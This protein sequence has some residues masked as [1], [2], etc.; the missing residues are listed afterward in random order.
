MGTI[1][2]LVLLAGVARAYQPGYYSGHTSQRSAITFAVASGHVSELLSQIT[3]SCNPGRWYV[4]LYPHPARVS[5]RGNWSHRTPGSFPTVYHGHLSGNRATGTIDD[6][7]RNA[8][9]RT[10]HGRVSF[11]ANRVNPLRLGTA[12]ISSRGTDV[13]VD[14]SLPAGSSDGQVVPYTALGLLVYASNTGCRGSYQAASA[15]ATRSSALIS[16]ESVTDA[17]R[18]GLTRSHGHGVFSF[19][20]FSPSVASSATGVKPFSTVCAMVYS[21][22]PASSTPARNVALG[23]ARASLRSG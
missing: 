22:K 17:Y 16:D 11:R 18:M 1:A 23:T 15:Q 20:V 2:S 10:C 4:T 14:L 6:T 3:D 9:G 8:A 7:S 5:S 12:S 19:D 13:A 21:G